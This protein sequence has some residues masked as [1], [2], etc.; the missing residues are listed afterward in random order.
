MELHH[1]IPISIIWENIPENLIKLDSISHIILHQTQNVTSKHIRNFRQNT[2]WIL[3]PDEKFFNLKLQLWN[4]FF[5][6]IKIVEDLQLDSLNRQ[7]QLNENY[8]AIDIK[9]ALKILIEIQ[10]DKV[11]KVINNYVW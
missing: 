8:E 1:T 11:Y 6:N 7:I 2:N 10:K 5:D 4:K 9:E 3:V